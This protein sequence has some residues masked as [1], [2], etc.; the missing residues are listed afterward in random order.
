VDYLE[1]LHQLACAVLRMRQWQR[2]GN[3]SE[4]WVQELNREDS[5][6]RVDELVAVI[7]HLPIPPLPAPPADPASRLPDLAELFP[8]WKPE[9]EGKP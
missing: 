7:L 8:Q 6:R 3:I 5:E 1:Q 2:D 4:G 9:G